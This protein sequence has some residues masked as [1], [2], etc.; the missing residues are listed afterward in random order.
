MK[1]FLQCLKILFTGIYFRMQKKS[2][3]KKRKRGFIP[4]FKYSFLFYSFLF[5]S[6]L[7][8]SFHFRTTKLRKHNEIN[9]KN[10]INEIYK[11]FY[12]FFSYFRI[13]NISN[14]CNF[15][16]IRRLYF[17]I[18]L[19]VIQYLLDNS[20]MGVFSKTS[21]KKFLSLS[22]SGASD[23]SINSCDFLVVLILW[24]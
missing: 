2:A 22:V 16:K 3:H 12:L 1:Q 19:S 23:H 18:P 13:W 7:F 6:F 20:L 10:E 17:E 21:N 15:S 14:W 9:E 24:L 8:Y 11:M 4:L 5:I